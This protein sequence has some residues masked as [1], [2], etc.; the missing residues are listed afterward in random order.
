M[1]SSF[2]PSAPLVEGG[3]FGLPHTPEEAEAVL[4]PVPW[5]ATVSY[6]AGTRNGPEAVLQASRQ[7][8]LLDRE[9]GKPYEKGISMLPIPDK[10]ARQSEDARQLAEPVIRAGGLV[11]KEMIEA[12]NGVN[13]LCREMNDWV[14]ETARTWLNR[15]K[16]V[17]VVGGDHSVPFGL[18][19]AVGERLPAFGIL[20]IDAHADLRNAYEGFTWSHASIMHNVIEHVPAVSRLVQVG[21]RDYSPDEFEFIEANSG[22]IFTH[23]DADLRNRVYAGDPWIEIV[24]DVIRDLPPLVHVSF[25]IDGLDPTLCPHTGT[26]VPGGLSFTEAVA[27]IREVVESGREIVAFDLNEVA[28]DP[29]GA[30]E[31]DGNVGARL[32]YKMIGFA[33]QSRKAPA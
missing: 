19:Q 10:I 28:P 26:P 8:D 33:F 9:A 30:S 7:L 3:I 6:G 15:K 13:H 11:N 32:I 27:L 14:A 12:A 29:S 18:I 5:E 4:I 20:H 1:S 31:W 16:L 23:F 21:I 22:R 24:R 17:G 25:D 2:D